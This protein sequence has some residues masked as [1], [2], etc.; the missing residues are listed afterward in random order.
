MLPK[1]RNFWFQK[2]VFLQVSA[3]ETTIFLVKGLSVGSCGLGEE[4]AASLGRLINSNRSPLLYLDMS[5]NPSIGIKGT[6]ALQASMDTGK[7]PV[8][9]DLQLCGIGEQIEKYIADVIEAKRD[10]KIRPPVLG[11]IIFQM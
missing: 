10:K 8:Y 5:A 6:A 1:S 4:S 2:S 3:L 11:N 9:L 7:P